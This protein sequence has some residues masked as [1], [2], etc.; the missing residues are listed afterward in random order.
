MR[1]LLPAVA[2]AL[3]GSFLAPAPVFAQDV[4]AI[5]RVCADLE[6]NIPDDR[7][8]AACTTL[9][10]GREYQPGIRA[11]AMGMRALVHRER[12]DF[13]NAVRDYDM[14]IAGFQVL[15][16][17]A[18]SEERGDLVAMLVS[19][20]NGRGATHAARG[21]YRRAAPDFRE[22]MRLDPANVDAPNNLCFSLA[23][24][25]E[26]LDEA[27][28][29]CDA[30]LALRPNDAAALDS[31]GLVGLRQ[32]RF[33]EAWTD[34]DAAVRL[35]PADAHYLY[36]RGV[37]ALRLGRTREGEAD[38]ARARNIDAGVADTYAGYGIRP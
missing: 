35:D 5:A 2:A 34:Y 17:A 12:G 21:D 33:Q 15:L 6:N 4:M 28:A 30:S 3:A 1:I 24:L 27:R 36:G 26:S 19:Q 16:A 32:A 23:A 20:H 22:A 29:A 8:I 18:G 7:Q 38:I 10:D 11:G 25:N 14:A 9:I 13:A 31:R 37:A